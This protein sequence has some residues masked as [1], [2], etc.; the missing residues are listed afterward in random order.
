MESTTEAFSRSGDNVYNTF[1]STVIE[2]ES[3]QQ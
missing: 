3:E 1:I 2:E